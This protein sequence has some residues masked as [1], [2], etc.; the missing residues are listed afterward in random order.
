MSVV[1]DAQGKALSNLVTGASALMEGRT[2]GL[3]RSLLS[4][5]VLQFRKL[6]G[7]RGV[8]GPHFSLCVGS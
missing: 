8:N 5:N 2:D 4:R 6:A 7:P 1:G 3:L